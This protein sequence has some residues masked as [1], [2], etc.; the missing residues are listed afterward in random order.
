MTHIFTTKSRLLVLALALV[1]GA[2]ALALTLKGGPGPKPAGAASH[3][4]APLIS[5][6]PASDIT[7]FFMFRS[8][9]P[10][11]AD[12]VAFIMDVFP[13]GEPSAGPNYYNFDPSVVYRIH[14]DNNRDGRAND[15]VLEFRFKNEIRGLVDQF[16]LPVSYLGC[17]VRTPP[18]A[19]PLPPITALDGPG[20]EGLGLRQRYS[21]TARHGG[22]ILSKKL[23]SGLIAVPSNVGP[24]TMPNYPALAAQGVNDVGN[25]IRVFAGQRGDPFYIDLGG[26]FDTLNF[27]RNPPLLTPAED[28][29][30]NVN[31]FGT[32]M[33]GS[34]NVQTIAIE[35]PAGL[36]TKDRKGADSTA[37]PKLGAYASTT[38]PVISISG[39]ED[40]DDNGDEDG[41]D[42]NAQIQRLA[43]PLVNELIIGTEDKDRWNTLAPHREAQFLDYYLN[44]R[45]ALALQL[46]FGVPAA[47]S[48]RQDLVDLLLKYQPTDRRLSELLRLDV[49]VP[50]T[51]L[52]AQR[53]M[54]VLATPPDPAGWPNGR[55]PKD[56]VTDIAVRVVGGPNYVAARAGDGVNKHFA[57]TSTDFPFLATPQ[58]GRNRVHENPL[59]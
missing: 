53:R 25:G 50:P 41:D 23:A 30:D 56:D 15:V 1:G 48:G 21:V 3:R 9:E 52:A 20:S 39:D 42:G 14:V 13:G 44:P 32:D 16:D 4:E 57:P 36:L 24:S 54:T 47:T 17:G 29:N 5:L 55:R 38:Q 8:Y 46:V 33:I 27:R 7:D 26:V 51:P 58:N 2:L 35:L 34:L 45:A 22:G 12:K 40:D 59:P 6:Y 49:S 43:N 31:P 10:G 37:Q 18:C 28:A 19:T 11:K